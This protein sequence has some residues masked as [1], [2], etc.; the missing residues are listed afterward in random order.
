MES[1]GNH[2]NNS[3][4]KTVWNLYKKLTKPHSNTYIGNI[5]TASGAPKTY[6]EDKSSAVYDI[7]SNIWMR[8]V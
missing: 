1:K 7:F 2:I 8:G 4:G 6:G 5:K 3:K